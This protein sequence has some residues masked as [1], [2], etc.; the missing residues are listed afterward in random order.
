MSSGRSAALGTDSDFAG[1]I[2][3]QIS[4]TVNSGVTVNGQVL[5]IDGSVTLDTNTITRPW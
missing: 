3:A 1:R 2:P 4:I 5:A